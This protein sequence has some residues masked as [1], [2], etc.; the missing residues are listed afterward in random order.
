MKVGANYSHGKGEFVVWA[1]LRIRVS[2]VL[3]SSNETFELRKTKGD[4]W[5][6]TLD[7]VKPGTKYMYRLD[8][9]IDRADPASHFLP[10]GIHGPSLVI[11]HND[12]EWTDRDWRGMR[13]QDAVFYELHIGT[14]TREGTFRAMIRRLDE[15]SDLGVNTVELM[16]V[17]QFSGDRNWGYDGVF[18]YAVQNTYGTPDEL[19]T[20]VNRCHSLDLAVV[21]DVVYNHLGP[22]GNCLKDY[23]PYFLYDQATPWG[24]R[25]NL[26]GQMNVPVRDYFIENALYWLR[27]YHFDGLRLDA[28]HAMPDSSPTHFLKELSQR[29]YR[30]ART[31]SRKLYLI[32]ESDLND[33]I[34]V[35]PRRLGGYGLDAQWL[36]DFHHSLH[37]LLTGEK[38]GYYSDF[39]TIQ[40]LLKALREGYVCTGQYSHYKKRRHGQSS[41]N[42]P[43]TKF[44]A[45]TQNHDQV[46]NRMLGGRLKTL[47]G[48]EA[49]K[50]AAGM[51][52]LSPYLPL[53]FMGEEYGEE[54]PFFFFTSYSDRTLAENIR[55]GRKKEFAKFNWQAEPPDP[56]KPETFLKSKIHWQQRYSAE[57]S[58]ILSYYKKLIDLRK[59]IPAFRQTYRRKMKFFTPGGSRLLFIKRRSPESD[60]IIVANFSKQTSTYR[61]PGES[62]NYLKAL[63]SADTVWH[64]PGSDLPNKTEKGDQHSI[65]SLSLAVFVKSTLVK[66]DG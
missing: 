43:P 46:G 48:L 23:G 65:K 1:P 47:A 30:H 55:T 21:L 26:D 20:L 18:P 17:A 50:L 39:G 34:V 60:V 41:R 16:P 57:G 59:T 4:Y 24:A 49:C 5:K 3:V 10:E 42:V 56:Q 29:V 2:V 53:L 36:D 13:I 33:P 15:L 38:N 37:T 45:S 22:E 64:G 66:N 44:I 8:C 19:K 58:R 12:F 61:F 25:V 51:V 7:Q 11:D 40:H 54:A 28:V 27:E 52:L 32:A 63:D 6:L 31:A 62:Q 14:F 9:D 35:T